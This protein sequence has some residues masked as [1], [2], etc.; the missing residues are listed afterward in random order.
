MAWDGLWDVVIVDQVDEDQ[1]ERERRRDWAQ[2]GA[3]GAGGWLQAVRKHAGI[4]SHI[5][6]STFDKAQWSGQTDPP[7]HLWAKIS[8]SL[9]PLTKTS[10]LKRPA[11]YL[12]RILQTNLNCTSFPH[13]LFFLNIQ[14]DIFCT[15]KGCL[16]PT[17][18]VSFM[19]YDLDYTNMHS[20]CI[21]AMTEMK[22]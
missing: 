10:R 6:N 12:Q 11:R 18:K 4:Y 9:H 16:F 3:A 17:G 5:N 20:C 1:E 21:H 22:Y 8:K 19:S 7:G 13:L 14:T 2:R 15:Q